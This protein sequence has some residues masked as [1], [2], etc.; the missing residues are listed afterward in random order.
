VKIGEPWEL[1][2][3]AE[4][5]QQRGISSQIDTYPLGAAI[6]GSR[7][8]SRIQ[9]ARLGLYVSRAD[10]EAVREFA[11]E[12]AASEAADAGDAE[13]SRDPGVCPACGEPTPEN[14]AACDSC[15]LEFPEVEGDAE[16]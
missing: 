10:L 8:G 3:L 12:L 16:H 9:A 5:L 1:R 13:L 14:A 6:A 7:A 4:S 11:A 2:A 15:G